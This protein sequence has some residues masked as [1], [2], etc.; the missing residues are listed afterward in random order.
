MTL[1]F[2]RILVT[3]GMGFIG[4]NFIRQLLKFKGTEIVN[5]DNLSIGSCKK[6]LSDL[7]DL[8]NYHFYKK[9]VCDLDLIDLCLKHN[10]DCIVHFAAE[11]HVD[12]SINNPDSF[13]N[14]NILGTYNLLRTSQKMVAQNSSFHFHH[15]STDEV[16][17]SLGE[18]DKAFTEK[19]QYQPN[20]PYSAS[21]AS[22]DHLVRSWHHTYGLNVTTS[23]C[24]N[25]YGPYQFPEKLIPVVIKNA[26]SGINIPIYGKGNNIRDW[27]FVEDHCDAILRIINDGIVG[28]TY[29]IGGKNEI[30]NFDI[31]LKICNILDEL[32]PLS[33]PSPYTNQILKLN[34]YSELISYVE[35]RPGHD[36]RY[37]IDPSKIEED[38]DWF[39][40]E[41]FESGINKTITWYLEN[42]S[43]FKYLDA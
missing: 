4:S 25:N 27:L 18:N 41:N 31:V 1:K 3:G 13:I 32:A 9:D 14:T 7:A 8:E 12:R 22:S 24:S 20:S 19:H 6:N 21:K 23:N 10:I 43:W 42:I 2:K 28:E 26:L 34:K 11:S 29:N 5:I 33:E 40:A 30:K 35:D 39:P 17:G 15:V 16:F 38:L 37:I 36:Q